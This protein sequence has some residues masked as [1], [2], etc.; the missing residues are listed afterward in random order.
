MPRLLFPAAVCACLLFSPP[1]GA[2]AFDELAAEAR[3]ALEAGRTDEA[4]SLYTKATTLRPGWSEGW[5]R[6]GTLQLDTRRF[7]EARDAFSQF[8]K[9]E[10]KQAGPG[11][12]MLGLC[13]FE[14][15][16]YPE[17]LDAL[18]RGIQAGLGSNP[19]FAR[20]VLYHAGILNSKAR[21][22][23]IAVR[24]L[25]LAL[26]QAAAGRPGIAP[27]ALLSD[28]AVVDALGIASLRLPLL[29]AEI[30]PVRKGVVHQA[31]R[32][33][34][35]F[36]LQDGPAATQEYRKLAAEYPAEA[37]VHYARGVFLL[38]NRSADAIAEFQREIEISPKDVDARMQIALEC[39]RVGDY[40]QGR[41]YAAE[42]VAL[43]PRHF[44]PRVANGRLLLAVDNVPAAIQE[45]EIAVRLAPGS[46]DARLALSRA[47][48][49]AGRPQDAAR[50]RA[51]FDR[52]E[53]L[54]AA[55]R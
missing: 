22:W 29:P 17:A 49:Q 53:K 12:G 33:R 20:E 27:Q 28:E 34:A 47:Y 2:Q 19:V 55:E 15:K 11:W 30:P 37:G 35:L 5:W 14:M 26:N 13:E 23:E 18:E 39:L 24:R 25:G 43:A 50:E 41:K 51:E 8:V 48:A 31:G 3:R 9:V 10:Q 38:K 32:A 16:R 42:A 4:V 45:L 52:I 7:L 40:E 36:E 44:A 6:L 1:A 46:P 54:N 21:R